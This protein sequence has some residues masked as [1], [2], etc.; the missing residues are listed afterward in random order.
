VSQLERRHSKRRPIL[1]TFSIFIVI[2]QKGL[3]RLAVHDMSEDGMNFNVDIEG[4]PIF[5]FQPKVGESIDIRIYLN[6]S[7][8]IPLSIQV[9]RITQH[10]SGRRVGAEFHHKKSESYKAFHTL[11]HLLDSIVNVL[12][13][14]NIQT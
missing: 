2:P 10:P 13:I 4:E 5:S 9:V 7:L 12:R 8:Y 14:D 11:L 6:K 1:E 3:Y